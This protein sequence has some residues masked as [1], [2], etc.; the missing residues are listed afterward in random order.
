MVMQ[1]R[2][3]RGIAAFRRARMRDGRPAEVQ[4]S[5]IVGANHLDHVGVVDIILRRQG[6]S[7]RRDIGATLL[8]QPGALIYELDALEDVEKDARKGN[9][10]A[11]KVAFGEVDPD[12]KNRVAG[13]LLAGSKSIQA[14]LAQLGLSLEVLE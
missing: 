11:L 10:N 3:P 5:A 6:R 13:Y 1:G 9:F 12:V 2:R 7:Q 4:R 14:G 8:Q